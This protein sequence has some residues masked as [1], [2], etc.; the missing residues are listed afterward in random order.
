MYKLY[1][2]FFNETSMSLVKLWTIYCVIYIYIYIYIYIWYL[3]IIYKC[4]SD[5]LKNV[6][7]T[8]SGGT[9]TSSSRQGAG[10]ECSKAIDGIIASGNGLLLYD[11]NGKYNI[12]YSYTLFYMLLL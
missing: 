12:E 8:A 6:A 10:Y 9:C 4:N 2:Y 7:S 5:G 1:Q 3:T 11:T